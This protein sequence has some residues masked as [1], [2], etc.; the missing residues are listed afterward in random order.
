VK[1]LQVLLRGRSGTNCCNAYQIHK[2]HRF[3]H[4]IRNGYC[5]SAAGTSKS[6]VRAVLTNDCSAGIKSAIV[7][8]FGFVF[9]YRD[10][11]YQD[12]KLS[13]VNT[14]FVLKR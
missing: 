5:G 7:I 14:G 4:Q 3:S 12:L 9:I 6:V 11:T 8:S 1:K 10:G 2:I 13:L